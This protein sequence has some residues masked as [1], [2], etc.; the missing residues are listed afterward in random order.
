VVGCNNDDEIVSKP[1][2]G[3]M[4]EFFERNGSLPNVEL[5]FNMERLMDKIEIKISHFAALS[6]FKKTQ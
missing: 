4:L 2:N 6:N 5:T 1:V 3:D